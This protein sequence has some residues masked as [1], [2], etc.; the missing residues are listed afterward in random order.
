MGSAFVLFAFIGV[1]V[2]GLSWGSSNPSLR[3]ST[4]SLYLLILMV[5]STYVI[6]ISFLLNSN[7]GNPSALVGGV[8]DYTASG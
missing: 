8:V 5:Y 2:Y 3:A 6:T 4:N 1:F 7:L